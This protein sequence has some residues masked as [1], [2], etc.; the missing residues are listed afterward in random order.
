[1]AVQLKSSRSRFKVTATAG[2]VIIGSYIV[3]KTF[4][5]LKDSIYNYLT[6]SGEIEDDNKPIELNEEAENQQADIETK[7]TEPDN[8]AE[9]VANWSDNT[10][11]SWL[12]DK[13]INAPPNA[14]H[15]SLVSLVES[16]K[17]T[18]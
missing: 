16:I 15:N 8:D 17:K 9:V 14:S 3:L 6:G 7:I 18:N 10:L 4:P 2:A 5:H 11:K 1:M 13:E 12:R